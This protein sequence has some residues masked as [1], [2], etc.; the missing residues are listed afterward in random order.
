MNY[1]WI[2]DP[3][4]GHFKII[5]HCNRPFKTVEE[6]DET[7]IGNCN[8]IIQKNDIVYCIGDFTFKKPDI[9]LDRLKGNWTLIRGNHDPN[10]VVRSKFKEVVESKI[11]KVNG[12]GIFMSHFAHRVWPH[13]Y[14]GFFHLF[15]HSHGTLCDLGKSCDVGVDV[16]NF[17]PVSFEEIK[18]RFEKKESE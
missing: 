1:Y 12:Q 10:S 17:K 2:A 4:L 16:W 9:Y 7:I 11:I 14:Y 6:M 18:N 8:A 13:S 15:G 5:Q 3:H